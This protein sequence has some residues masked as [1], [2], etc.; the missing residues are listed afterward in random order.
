MEV[1]AMKK[2]GDK[3]ILKGRKVIGGIA[4]GEALVSKMPLMGWGN[5]DSKNGYTTERNHP[6]YEI[7]FKGKVLVF[8]EPRGSGG[9]VGYGRTRLFGTQPAA[10]VYRKGN[11]L[12][13]FAAM[14]ADIPTVT[15]F[16]QDPTE[17]IETGDHVIVNGDE[18]IVE[19]IKKHK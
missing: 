1:K 19:V 16:D 11:N 5:V 6:L 17:V 9:F 18:G 4:E 10:F 7:P 13:V 2:T 14:A 3:I 8:T 15:D 12:T